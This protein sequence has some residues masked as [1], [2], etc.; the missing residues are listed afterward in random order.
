MTKLFKKNVFAL[1]L[2]TLLATVL[3]IIRALE[4]SRYSVDAYCY[5]KMAK[6]WAYHGVEYM[7]LCEGKEIPPLLPWLMAMG[8]NFGLNPEYTGLIIGIVLGSLMPLAAFWIVLNLFSCSNGQNKNIRTIE[9]FLPRNYVYA[10]L[11]AFFVVVHPFFIR[12]S[13]SCLREIVYLP[14]FAFAMA[15]AL[16]AIYNKSLWKWCIFAILAAVANMARRE[17]IMIIAIFFAWQLFELIIDWKSFRKD[18]KYYITASIVVIVVFSASMVP[19]LYIL[20]NSSSI[21]SPL[22]FPDPRFMDWIRQIIN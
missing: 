11:A 10:L 20:R 16:S 22:G 9:S 4:E 2:I 7:C 19:A 8:Y 1:I 21:W 6:N 12:I 18:I 5:F 13:V 3:R 15:F 17:G 14:A